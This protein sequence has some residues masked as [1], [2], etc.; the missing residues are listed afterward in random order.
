MRS[1]IPLVCLV[2][3]LVPA[4][5]AAREEKVRL[6]RVPQPVMDA[7]KARFPTAKPTEAA[8]EEEKGQLVYEVGLEDAGRHVDV[9]LSPTGEML[10][11]ERTIPKGELPGAVT[12]ALSRAY[13][14]AGY[15]TVEEIVEVQAGHERLASYEVLLVPAGGGKREVKV[16]PD[17]ASVTEETDEP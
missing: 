15:R 7:V 14:G 10:L 8:K 5:V 2:A 1:R 12:E 11:I 6:D 17:G 4:A 16:S 9:T 3:L 13:P